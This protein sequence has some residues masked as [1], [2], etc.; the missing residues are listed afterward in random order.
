[1]RMSP[2]HLLQKRRHLKKKKRRQ[3]YSNK[4]PINRSQ[5]LMHSPDL[6]SAGLWQIEAAAEA[7]VHPLLPTGSLK[8]SLQ[9]K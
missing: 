7:E 4:T 9:F 6:H 1:M 2:L 5:L 8:L 3:L